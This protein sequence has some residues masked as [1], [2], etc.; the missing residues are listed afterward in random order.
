MGRVRDD[1]D[2]ARY[3][4]ELRRNGALRRAL[5]RDGLFDGLYEALAWLMGRLR[6]A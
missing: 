4:A 3:R 6:R 2:Q 5:L 1:D